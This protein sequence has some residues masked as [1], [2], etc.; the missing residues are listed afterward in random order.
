M[1]IPVGYFRL[2]AGFETCVEWCTSATAG[3]VSMLRVLLVREVRKLLYLSLAPGL[4]LEDSDMTL[5]LAISLLKTDVVG[6]KEL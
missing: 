6:D 5:C 1:F 2:V 3:G 4:G